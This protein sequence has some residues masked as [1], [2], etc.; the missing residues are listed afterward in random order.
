M[1][2][3]ASRFS[4]AVYYRGQVVDLDLNGYCS[5]EFLDYGNIQKTK[6]K[7]LFREVVCTEIPP[8]AQR[9]R[10][11]GSPTG[12][13]GQIDQDLLDKLHVTIVDFNI[14]INVIPEDASKIAPNYVK[15]C[16][17]TV[18]DKVIKSY[19]N[20]LLSLDQFIKPVNPPALPPA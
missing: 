11:E 1:E 15:R 18:D 20:F 13:Y 19:N 10:L 7:K 14:E 5:V 12:A 6:M 4:F 17:I 9:Y 16:W 8:L 3:V 2:T